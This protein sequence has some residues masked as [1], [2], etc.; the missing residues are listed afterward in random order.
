MN[1]V[2]CS[3]VM[4]KQKAGSYSTKMISM[5]PM[6]INRQTIGLTACKS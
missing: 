3:V 1:D 5:Q 2:R 6:L 4:N